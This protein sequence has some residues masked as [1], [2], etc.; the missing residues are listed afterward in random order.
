MHL[1]TFTWQRLN[2]SNRRFFPTIL[3]LRNMMY[4]GLCAGVKGIL[5][6]D[7]SFDLKNN[8]I[9]LWNEFKPLRTDV[10]TLESALMN[11][12]LTRVNTG[13]PELVTSYWVYNNICYMAVVNTSYTSSKAV[14]I[15]LPSSYTGTK[16]SLFSRMPNTLSVAGGNFTGTIGAQQV[17]VYSIAQNSD[18]TLPSVPGGLN[19]SSVTAFSFSLSWNPSTGGAAGY[20]VFRN[21]TSIGNTSSISINVTSL[22]CNTSYTMTVKS[23]D[24]AEN[25]KSPSTPLQVTTSACQM[26]V[27]LLINPG[28]ENGITG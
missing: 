13:N 21:G 23:F 15:P 6:Y 14:S 5:S 24:A 20:G 26:G 28:F 18:T 8:Q 4:S 27:N 1:Q 17:Q 12:V 10:T 7:F 16:T 9:P 25:Y 2:L 22:S 19:S 11:G 3:E